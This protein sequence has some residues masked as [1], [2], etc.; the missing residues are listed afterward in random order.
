ML[1]LSRKSGFTLVETLCAL[2]IL[3]I[4]FNC[5]IY[6]Q[7]NNLKLKKYNKELSKYLY[8]LEGIKKEIMYNSSYDSVRNLHNNQKKYIAKDKLTI[9]NVRTLELEQLFDVHTQTNDIYLV[10]SVDDGEVLKIELEL[11]L[12]LDSREEIIKCEFYKGNYI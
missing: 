9:E 12:K 2:G 4:M 10:M 5:I 6:I 1:K 7:L 3:S 8:V 11:Y